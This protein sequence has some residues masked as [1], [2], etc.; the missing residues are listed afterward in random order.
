MTTREIIW[1]ILAIIFVGYTSL[2]TFTLVH[3]FEQ[4]KAQQRVLLCFDEQNNISTGD[5]FKE[6]RFVAIRELSK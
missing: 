2:I 6:C 1:A 4:N 5:H 3:Y